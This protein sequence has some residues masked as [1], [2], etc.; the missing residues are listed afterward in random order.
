MPAAA[1]KVGLTDRSLK[2]LRP[3]PGGE[4][5]IVWDALLPGMAVRVSGKGKRSFYAVKRRQGAAQP[6][7][8]LLGAYPVMGLGE[9]RA[10]AR[11][12]LGALAEGHDPAVL[13]A[14]KRGAAEEAEVARKENTFAAVAEAF[15]KRHAS[16][17]RQGHVTE[18]IIRRELIPVWGERPIAAITRRDVLKLADAILDRGGAQPPA[19]AHRASGGPF[20]ARH[21]LSVTRT[22]FNWAIERDIISA[23]PCDRIKAKNLLGD[24]SLER[25]RVLVDDEL[26]AVWNAA[27][28][29]DYPYGPLVRV[30]MLTGQRRDEIASARWDE[31]DL[32]RATLTIGAGR[33]KAKAGHAVPLTPA[34]VEILAGLPRFTAGPFIFSGRDGAAPFSGFSKCKARLDRA[35]GNIAPYTLHDLRRTVRTRL[36]E[37][38]VTPFIA[39]L[40]LAHTPKGVHAVYDLH[41]YTE[42]KRDALMRWERRLLAIVTPEAPDNVVPIA[43]RVR[44]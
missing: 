36:A 20:A 24:V 35:A 33:M 21:A 42:E 16:K 15:I 38:G 44:A 43:A 14:A 26:R 3:A 12:A 11:E 2:A 23:S 22:L 13:A 4:R 37:L 9:A 27:A 41:R 28:Q 18:G 40:V 32:D 34:A 8:V 6:S 1:R 25:D 39:E 5:T 17:L 19:G 31:L 29:T 7:W 10:K 30:L